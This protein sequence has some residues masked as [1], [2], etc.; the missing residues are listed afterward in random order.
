MLQVTNDE[1]EEL[2][3]FFDAQSRVC[4]HHGSAHILPTTQSLVNA[5]RAFL[6]QFVL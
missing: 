4:V 5:V 1:S 6:E 3:A 2:A